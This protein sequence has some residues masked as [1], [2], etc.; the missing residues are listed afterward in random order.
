MPISLPTSTDPLLLALQQA[1]EKL[2]WLECSELCG[3]LL[4]KLPPREAV[5]LSAAELNE[6]LPIFE[7]YRPKVAWPRA[8]LKYFSEAAPLPD[9]FDFS[10]EVEG[11]NPIITHF[12][13]GLDWLDAAAADQAKPH[14]CANECN[15][16]ILSAISS[17]RYEYFA[18]LFP[19]DWRIV[20]KREAGATD[21]PPMKTR[22]LDESAVEDYMAGMWRKLSAA[23][24]ERLP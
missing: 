20:V 22:F 3:L 4:E 1:T 15:R 5:L 7:R 8:A 21:L 19:Q 13:E 11:A 6:C 18:K 9:D 14:I 24:A 23:L 12:L 10:P 17:R 2:A 16:T